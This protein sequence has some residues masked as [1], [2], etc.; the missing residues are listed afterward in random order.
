[1][2]GGRYSS[3]GSKDPVP[4]HEPDSETEE[5]IAE[6]IFIPEDQE[7]FLRVDEATIIP[8]DLVEFLDTL[9]S[10]PR[11]TEE[12]LRALT[13]D[14]AE[15]GFLT[16][17]AEEVA[18]HTPYHICDGKLNRQVPSTTRT[19]ASSSSIALREDESRFAY[20]DSGRHYEFEIRE[21]VAWFRHSLV[22]WRTMTDWS[23]IQ[24]DKM[25]PQ[26]VSYHH[27][28]AGQ[29]QEA[30]QFDMISASSGRVFA[31]E[32][33]K[34]N[35]YFAILDPQFI[36]YRH[37]GED[38]PTD[39]ISVPGTYF[40]LDPEQN[41]PS[42][43]TPDL[44]A[45]LDGEFHDHPATEKFELFKA[46]MRTRIPDF[47]V[48]AVREKVWHL[49]DTR[50]PRDAAAIPL[51]IPTYKHVKYCPSHLAMLFG[52]EEEAKEAIDFE[53][54]LDIGVGHVHWHEKAQPIYGGEMQPLQAEIP[55]FPDI[56]FY[57]HLYRFLNGPVEDGDGFIDGTCNYYI[58][59]RLRSDTRARRQQYAILVL[60][61]QSFFSRR[62][63][64]LHP[65][66][67][68]PAS[69]DFAHAADL[70]VL[71][72]L[73]LVADLRRHPEWYDGFE[74]EK[75]WCPFE[76]GHITEQSRMAVSRQVVLVSGKDPSSGDD[77]LYSI[78][79]SWATCDHTWRY[80]A[81][82]YGVAIKYLLKD[83][84]ESGTE[85][86]EVDQKAPNAIYPQTVRL[87]EDMTIHLKGTKD[88]GEIPLIGRWFQKYLPPDNSCVPER[89]K[90]TGGKPKSGYDHAWQFLPEETFRRAD[91][92]S[93]FGVYERVN[94]RSQYY[95][96]E[97]SNPEM[98]SDLPEDTA[99]EDD[100]T[101]YINALTLDWKAI[102]ESLR[103]RVIGRPPIRLRFCPP[104][105]FNKK[106]ILKIAER[107]PVG[108]IAMHW[109]KRDDDLSEFSN[110][111]PT[112][113]TLSSGERRL[114]IKIIGY[115]TDP[116]PPV[117]Q[118]ANVNVTRDG[119]RRVTGI[120]VRYRSRMRS[121]QV[122]TR[123]HQPGERS[124]K[125]DESIW[126]I[127]IGALDDECPGGVCIFFDKERHGNFKCLSS[128]DFWFEH[129]WSPATA[130]AEQFKKYC[131]EEGRL[132]FGT[133][134][135]FEDIV[136][137]MST[138]EKTSFR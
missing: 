69:S 132:T 27:R 30:P 54:V 12:I 43:R 17:I 73:A 46:V 108:W 107:D 90:L 6:T 71:P 137:H 58:L 32:K 109:D 117:V 1:M 92:F 131:T 75:F 16:T 18:R 130:E 95:T 31:K 134:I 4:D 136:G 124:W 7:G 84:I 121:D 41:L 115:H 33:G 110:R 42:E 89:D 38:D 79:F 127:K 126:R 15:S 76:T 56:R 81:F 44:L 68:E 118:E 26:S 36:Q 35:F 86:I 72:N 111:R 14:P 138:A 24:P 113:L 82:P 112:S 59:C 104:S 119:E 128:D 21:G 114:H 77:E 13:S 23:V 60:D 9:G 47:M 105:L 28:R 78:N 88:N 100:D 103:N 53:R 80:R 70:Q 129:R 25:G 45:H 106:T 91:L 50:S 83:D 65:D 94:S 122:K 87:R 97:V 5:T 2:E 19:F 51:G 133:S 37:S 123:S 96:L 8:H 64:L 29:M 120:S 101:L 135:W 55:W 67:C 125:P 57:H 62:W 10:I 63:R 39:N 40:K 85:T 93:H 61:E 52:A 48:V 66:D 102:S 98:L 99:W 22:D 34:D 116:A 49:L 11:Q 74:V 20:R 3:D